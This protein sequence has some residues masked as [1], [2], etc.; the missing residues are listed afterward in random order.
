MN[1]FLF[2]LFLAVCWGVSLILF[3]KAMADARNGNYV[4]TAVS[5][6]VSCGILALV[7]FCF[8]NQFLAAV[9]GLLA[10]AFLGIDP[11]GMTQEKAEE[12]GKEYKREKALKE[13]QEE[14][15]R[16]DAMRKAQNEKAYQEAIKELKKRE[17]GK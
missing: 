17:S 8:Y 4:M 15:E 2:V 11:F 7:W 1:Y 16:E 3:G 9:L 10:G 14:Q 6:A 13:Q 5:I 12:I